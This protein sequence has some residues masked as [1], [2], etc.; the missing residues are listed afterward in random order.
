[1][2]D[3]IFPFYHCGTETKEKELFRIRTDSSTYVQFDV[4]ENENK[5][6]YL[7]VQIILCQYLSSGS[8]IS[9]VN[10]L[11][12]EIFGTDV[13]YSRNFFLDIEDQFNNSLII[14]ATSSDMY[15]QYQF[16]NV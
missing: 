15:I 5:L 12:E 6:R 2:K 3:L 7:F 1:M 4:A 8:H 10:D 9:F 11:G 16:I 13:V 14:N